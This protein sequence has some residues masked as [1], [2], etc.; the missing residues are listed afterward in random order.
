V[1]GALRLTPQ[2]MGHVL[3]ERRARVSPLAQLAP[4]AGTAQST[5][6]AGQAGLLGQPRAVAIADALA[7]TVKREQVVADGSGEG[8]NTSSRR[9][10]VQAASTRLAA[11]G[12]GATLRSSASRTTARRS[13]GAQ[14]RDQ[15]R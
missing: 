6:T 7:A 8:R 2:G 15:S 14:R 3:E 1:A 5:G 10:S 4:A 11:G 12:N 13:L 9:V